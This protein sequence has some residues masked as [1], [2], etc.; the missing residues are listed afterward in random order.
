MFGFMSNT[1][2]QDDEDMLRQCVQL[3]I[4]SNKLC[5]FHY[6]STDVKLKLLKSD[7]A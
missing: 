3:Y 2:A 5:T 4:R 6:C 7:C 1:N